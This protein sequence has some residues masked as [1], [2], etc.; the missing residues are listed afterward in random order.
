MKAEVNAGAW[1]SCS[2]VYKKRRGKTDWAGLGIGDAFKGNLDYFLRMS[3]QRLFYASCRKIQ[4]AAARLAGVVGEGG[5]QPK[6]KPQLGPCYTSYPSALAAY[7]AIGLTGFLEF[8]EVAGGGIL[9]AYLGDYLK[10]P[11]AQ[12][13]VRAEPGLY[14]KMAYLVVQTVQTRLIL[15]DLSRSPGMTLVDL[16]RLFSAS[17]QT[18]RFESVPE[19]IQ[20]VILYGDVLPDWDGQPLHPLTRAMLRDLD[21]LSRPYFIKLAASNSA[22]L[23]PLGIAWARA[24]CRCLAPYLPAAK[25]EPAPAPPSNRM[26]PLNAPTPPALF[27]PP[28]AVERATAALMARLPAAGGLRALMGMENPDPA[29]AQAIQALQA[30]AQAL[31]KAGGQKRQW[32]DMRSDLVERAM[33][34]SAFSESPIQGNPTDGHDVKVRLGSDTVA[35]G[36]IHDRPV[37]LSEDWAAYGKLMGDAQ[38]VAEALRRALYPNV[39]ERVETQR[40]RATGSLD[41]ARLSLADCSQ[42]VFKRYRIHDRAD[43]KGHPLL[44]IA[45]D[46]SGSLSGSQMKMVKVMAAA[47]LTATARSQVQVMAGL[48]HSGEIRAGISGPLVQWMVHPLKTPAI[49]RREAA[50]AIVSLPETGTGVQSDA[51]SLAF[52]LKEAARVARG[53]R[54]YLVLISD[55]QWNRSFSVG[56]SGREEVLALF[57]NAYEEFSDN[58]HT[59]LVALGAPPQADF[60]ARLD[61]VVAV[62]AGKLEDYAGLA[63]QVGVYVATCMKERRA[64]LAKEGGG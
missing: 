25:E 57:E 17:Q 5:Y 38:P 46:G 4:L 33:K 22:G 23:A 34:A 15:E 11:A 13:E 6:T 48:Y 43:R 62:P 63:E 26:A 24:V 14:Q 7:S 61:K 9:A 47:W 56:K 40:F 35:A 27:A 16:F 36:D 3:A 18:L 29:M 59:T 49:S 30:F 12:D 44:L 58:L 52:M 60:E 2:S 28:T 45:C 53:R 55:C 20:A 19:I 42:A 54:I 32:E 31:E 10:N 51:L 21:A 1:D 39:E 50:H 37:E 64:L 41:P 8:Q